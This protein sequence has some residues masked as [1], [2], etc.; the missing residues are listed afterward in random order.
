[1]VGV[2]VDASE[3]SVD[4]VWM[5]WPMARSASANTEGGALGAVDVVVR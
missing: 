1:M 4:V 5:V 2:M 3:M